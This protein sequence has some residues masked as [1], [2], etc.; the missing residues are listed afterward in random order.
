[1]S[2][3]AVDT[4][5]VIFKD[6][7]ELLNILDLTGLE[8]EELRERLRDN[9]ELFAGT[10]NMYVTG[11]T[12]AG[13]TALGNSL[14][15]KSAMKSTGNIDCTDSVG[16]FKLASNL[17]YFDLPGAGNSES[18]ENINRAAL[19]IRQITDEYAEPPIVPVNGFSVLDYSGTEK[20]EE[21]YF[22]VERWQSPEQQ[23]FVKPDII[24]YVVAPDK[25]F[26]RPDRQYLGDLLTAWKKHRNI[27]IFALNIFYRDGKRLPTQQNIDDAQKGITQLYQ[28][29]YSTPDKPPIIEVNSLNGTGISEITKLIC[30]VL[31][32]EKIGKMQ[33][34]LKNDLKQFAQKERSSRYQDKLIRIASRL[35]M[36][37]VDRQ[38]GDQDLLAE[39]ATAIIAYGI[40]TFKS[41]DEFEKI[42]TE[43]DSV[44]EGYAT[45]VKASRSED[46]KRTENITEAKEITKEKEI[47]KD[48][49]ITEY[50]ER[51]EARVKKQRTKRSGL[52]RFGIGILEAVGQTFYSPVTGGQL[53]F[54]VDADKTMAAEIHRDCDEG[55]HKYV[56]TVVNEKVRIPVKRLE[57]RYVGTETE[58]IGTVQAVVGQK[59]VIVG[60]KYL[61]GGYPV[62]KFLLGI[63]LGVQNFY[64]SQNGS[65]DL[66]AYLGS[67]MSY[68]EAFVENKLASVR[69][70][71]EQLVESSAQDAEQKLIQILEQNLMD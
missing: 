10:V 50:V 59:E 11:R 51:E 65:Q 45:E 14:L 62:I 4:L 41:A 12:G 20:V 30:Q 69:G 9:K 61:K 71:I 40:M 28:K 68:G 22:K 13:K 32:Q 26:L 58:V 39:A 66:Q 17:R 29:V 34:V 67:V 37:T 3:Q 5:Q 56:E 53:L 46:I 25:Q 7:P 64:T 16:F 60:K 19:S 23:Q 52:A 44:V 6:Q 2:R 54:G 27:V 48:V 47:Y 1:M 31:P 38:I 55:A 33:R 49:E 42:A 36:H 70:L 15:G 21:E 35:A 57:K 8:S 43:L 63:G 18:Y 24:L